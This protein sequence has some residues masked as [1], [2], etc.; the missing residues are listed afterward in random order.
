MKPVFHKKLT[1]LLFAVLLLL[2]HSMPVMAAGTR[3]R[4]TSTTETRVP[5]KGWIR[6]KLDYE[7]DEGVTGLCDDII[8]FA[9]GWYQTDGWFYYREPVVP[10]DKVRFITGIT[11]PAEWTEDLQNK[12]FAVIVT[13]EAAEAVQKD[14][15]YFQN[16]E[17]IYSETFDLW[18]TGYVRPENVAI[19]EG[20]LTVDIHEYQL[21]KDGDEVP[22]VNDKV[23]V[24]GQ[25]ISKIVEFE[26]KGV[27][28]GNT[29]MD[30]VIE[31][32]KT[33]QETFLVLCAAGLSAAA[34]CG[35]VLYKRKKGGAG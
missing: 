14:S 24:P 30:R 28:G 29:I 17:A 4:V 22:Y 18:S 6:A 9:E 32:I 26:L 1:A 5:N 34:G 33:G 11:V 8:D 13:V 35:Y 25:P 12:N 20:R 21:N 3:S 19:R 10:G 31:I 27:P 23:I 16:D 2:S 15:G 7:C